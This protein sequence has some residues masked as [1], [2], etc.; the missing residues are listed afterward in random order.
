MC[1]ESQKNSLTTANYFVNIKQEITKLE[2][3]LAIET[4]NQLKEFREKTGVQIESVRV[5]MIHA[6][7]FGEEQYAV[8]NVSCKIAL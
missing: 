8:E 1:L 6:Q 5:E 4:T 2:E 3:N 7:S